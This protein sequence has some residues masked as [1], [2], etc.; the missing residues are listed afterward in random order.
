[1]AQNKHQFCI[2]YYIFWM[3]SF[4]ITGLDGSI[5]PVILPDGHVIERH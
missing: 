1:M 2:D 3:M 5:R 4:P